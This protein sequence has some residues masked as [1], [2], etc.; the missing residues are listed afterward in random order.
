MLSGILIRAHCNEFILNSLKDVI[1]NKGK[2]K[3]DIIKVLQLT[4]FY[5][6]NEIQI[7]Y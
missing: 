2:F 5:F 3:R 4:K 7:L 6:C 1:E